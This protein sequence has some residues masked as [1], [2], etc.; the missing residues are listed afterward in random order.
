V[1]L[2]F[3]K[4]EFRC[5]LLVIGINGKDKIEEL[6]GFIKIFNPSGD[7]VF[8][9]HNLLYDYTLVIHIFVNLL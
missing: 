6:D 3:F 8:K 7:N 9:F 4:S 5:V 1:P 2:G